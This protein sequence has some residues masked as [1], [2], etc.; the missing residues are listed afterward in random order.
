MKLLLLLSLTVI[1][2]QSS[3]AQ[4]CY[5]F[6]VDTVECPT[7]LEKDC[8]DVKFLSKEVSLKLAQFCK[9]YT[10]EIDCGPPAHNSSMEIDKPDLYYSIKKLS[11]Y[12]TK[13]LKKGIVDQQEA[14]KELN[15]V[16][17]KCI[18]IYSQETQP[19]ENE[20]RSAGNPEEILSVFNKIILE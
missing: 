6:R 7:V 18:A 5:V 10:R 2:L 11:K 17:E 14:E 15:E 9:V 4:D 3:F 19:V 1:L 13:A 20:L 12:Y 8:P 16:L